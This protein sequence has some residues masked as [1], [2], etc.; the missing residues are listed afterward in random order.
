MDHKSPRDG[1]LV[2]QGWTRQF[3][4]SEP[5]L[6][7]A[8]E[9]Y[10]ELGLEVLLEPLDA[11]PADDACTSCFI[12]HPEYLKVIYTRPAVDDVPF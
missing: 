3:S 9:A 8:V 12:D 2:G 1:E 5:R 11:C 10:R 6:S 7:E 4:A